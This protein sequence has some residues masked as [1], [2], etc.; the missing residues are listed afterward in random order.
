MGLGVKE[1][2]HAI[3]SILDLVINNY[4][5]EINKSFG[6]GIPSLAFLENFVRIKNQPFLKSIKN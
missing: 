1:E 5:L 6:L 2:L 3:H 4:S